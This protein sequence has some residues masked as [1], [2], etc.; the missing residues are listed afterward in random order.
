[1]EVDLVQEVQRSLEAISVRLRGAVLLLDAPQRRV[2]S[3]WLEEFVR[4]HGVH[5]V[6]PLEDSTAGPPL[7]L[8]ALWPTAGE[9]G[10]AVV[11]L[12]SRFATDH[13][14]DITRFLELYRC[15]SCLVCTP[16]S[17]DA[18][19]NMLQLDYSQC[20]QALVDATHGQTR[21]DVQHLPVF[22]V[23]QQA[24]FL[25]PEAMHVAVSAGELAH[26]S[27]GIQANHSLNQDDEKAAISVP[28]KGADG[29]VDGSLLLQ[30]G[31]LLS[32]G[33]ALVSKV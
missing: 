31:S 29:R 20:A 5:A 11:V 3:G 15:D 7:P 12:V 25:L 21:V 32:S 19:A 9:H 10:N 28:T 2:L 18:H 33:A 26:G 14:D 8:P 16:L 6:L 27:K 30:S 4:K 17:A 23:I 13:A 22:H 1:M 24:S